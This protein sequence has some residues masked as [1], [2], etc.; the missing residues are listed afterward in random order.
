MNRPRKLDISEFITVKD[1]SQIIHN[2]PLYIKQMLDF[3]KDSNAN[4]RIMM[5]PRRSGKSIIASEIM[6][7]REETTVKMHMDSLTA[8]LD[9]QVS[10]II[11]EGIRVTTSLGEGTRLDTIRLDELAEDQE[12]YTFKER[13]MHDEAIF[14]R[15]TEPIRQLRRVKKVRAD[16]R[17]TERWER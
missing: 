10:D 9:K 15:A 11:T 16:G 1:Y 13:Y 7:A 12:N 2:P 8:C 14:E 17:I 3:I 5:S 4:M 6:R